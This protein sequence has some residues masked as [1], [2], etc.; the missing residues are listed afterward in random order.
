V[1]VVSIISVLESIASPASSSR[2]GLSKGS[3]SFS[4]EG[5][6]GAGVCAGVRSVEELL[7][8]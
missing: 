6:D 2:T 7:P 1:R 3:F 8:W 4:E 5:L